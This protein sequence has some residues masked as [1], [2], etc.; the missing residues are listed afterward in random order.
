MEN[1]KEKYVAVKEFRM[2]IEQMEGQDAQSAVSGFG[3]FL[4]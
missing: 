3:K 1:N 2:D 4:R